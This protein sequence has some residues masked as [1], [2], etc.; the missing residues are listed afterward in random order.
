LL[1]MDGVDHF[2]SA[3]EKTILQEIVKNNEMLKQNIS[4]TEDI[5]G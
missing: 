1:N 4:P 5:K 3:E 2:L